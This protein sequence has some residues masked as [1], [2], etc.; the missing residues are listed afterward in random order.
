[1]SFHEAGKDLAQTQVKLAQAEA[2]KQLALA[3]QARATAQKEKSLTD[4]GRI[5]KEGET[6]TR[7]GPR[8]MKRV[9]SERD[10]QI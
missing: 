6:D 8:G 10:G 1:M 7:F 3:E 2:D 5:P 4:G 9:M